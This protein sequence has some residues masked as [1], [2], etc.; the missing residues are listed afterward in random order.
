MRKSATLDQSGQ[1]ITSAPGPSAVLSVLAE[2]DPLAVAFSGGVDSA[3]VLAGAVRAWGSARTLAVI[4]DS[5]ALAR[6]ELRDA[7]RTAAEI[8]APLVVVPT[9]EWTVAGYRENSGNRCYFCKRTVLARVAD[10]A[11]AYG[12]HG[13]ATGTHRDDRRAPHRPGLRAAAE[14]G[15]A[16][17]LAEAGLGKPEVRAVAAAWGL[18]VAE[19]PGTPCLASRVAVGVPVTRERL[20]L[21]ER[22]EELVRAELARGRVPLTDVRVRLFATD[23]RVEL[24]PPAYDWVTRQPERAAALS[25]RVAGATRRGPGAVAPYRVGAVSGGPTDAPAG[26]PA[27]APS[28][29]PAS[30]P[31]RPAGAGAAGVVRHDGAVRGTEGACRA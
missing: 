20:G 1:Q 24:G 2:S 29:G 28:T 14:L 16:E 5:P 4:A 22:A 26:A 12:F 25:R 30:D 11:A 3:V 15:V 21:V 6:N 9:D 23:F 27:G 10:V 18:S 8:G 17:P 7:R 19:K 31:A 13:V